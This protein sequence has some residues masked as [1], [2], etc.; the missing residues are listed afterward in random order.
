MHQTFSQNCCFGVKSLQKG[1]RMKFFKFYGKGS[2]FSD[3]RDELTS[4]WRLK[5]VLNSCYFC[6]EFAELFIRI[7]LSVIKTDYRTIFFFWKDLF[8]DQGHSIVDWI[9]SPLA[10]SI[11]CPM[12][13]WWRV[14]NPPISWRPS[15]YCLPSLFQ[16]FP[17]RLLLL[18]QVFLLPCFF[19]W[20]CDHT[21][22]V[23]PESP[24]YVF[25]VTRGQVYCRFGRWH[26]LC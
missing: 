11:V 26:G 3:F 7:N 24:C 9:I 22:S 1:P 2:I 14:P 25:Y 20:I 19:G 4:G 13:S 23:V 12:Y 8:C 5:I 18:P 6:F 21:I 17:I 10:I 15:K 16:I